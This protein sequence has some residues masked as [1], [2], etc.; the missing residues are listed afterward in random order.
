MPR[1]AL[2]VTGDLEQRG[3][4]ASLARVFPEADFHIEAKLNGFT[5][6]T[7]PNVGAAP[8]PTLVDKLAA[9][10]VAAVDPG[11]TGTP[12]DLAIAIDDLEIANLHQPGV[13]VA[14]FRDA[15][16]RYVN[17]KWP[18][19]A[20]QQRAYALLRERASFHLLSPMPEAYFFSDTSAL[21]AAGV[22]ASPQLAPG[23]DLEDFTVVDAPYLAAPTGSPGWAKSNRARHPKHYLQYLIDPTE[24]LRYRETQQGLAALGRVE[25]AA[26]SGKHPTHLRLLRSLLLDLSHGLGQQARIPAGPDHPATALKQPGVLRNA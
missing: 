14:T 10:L 13:V 18:S 4:A 5:T 21:A 26:L 23:V 24:G 25:W 8:I 11:R 17:G 15:V 6:G 1:V 3:L 22:S 2:V 7:L 16:T 19:T 12:S 20:R 9:A